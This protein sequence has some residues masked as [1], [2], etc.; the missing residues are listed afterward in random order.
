MYGNKDITKIPARVVKFQV[1]KILYRNSDDGYTIFKAKFTNYPYPAEEIP[2]SEIIIIGHFI[3]IQEE[4]EF[5][6][7]GV[8]VENNTYGYQFK[9]N[10]AEMHHPVS[11]KGIEKFLKRFVKGI[12][13]KTA[14]AIVDTYKEETL[15]VIRKDCTALLKIPGIGEKR[16]NLIHQK[17]AE[18]YKFEQIAMFVLQHGVGYKACMRIYETFGDDSIRKIKEDPY[19]LFNLPKITFATADKF[20]KN[21]NFKANSSKRVKAG[22]RYYIE[23]RMKNQGDLFVFRDD[24]LNKVPKFLN[25]YGE[26]KNI[27]KEELVTSKDV[28]KVIEELIS[29]K[30]IVIENN[31]EGNECVYLKFYNEVENQIVNLLKKLIEEKKPPIALSSQIDTFIENYEKEHSFKFAQKQKEAI[32]MAIGNGI[33]IL[34]GGPGTGKTQT[35]NSIIKCIKSIKPGASIEL[36]A[37]TGK[38]SKRM[39]ELSGMEAKTI[40]RLIGLNGF[41]KNNKDEVFE[42]MADFLIIDESSMIDAYVFYK[43]LEAINGDTRVLIVGDY[44]QL[45]SVGP[46]LILRDLIASN[47][48]PTTRLTEIFRQAQE[49]QIVM[50]SHK[51]IKGHTTKGVNALTFDTSKNDF[52]FIEKS[53]KIAVQGLLIKCIENLINNQGY[54]ISDIQMLSPIRMGD[55]GTFELNRLIQK[56][57]NPPHV[58]KQEVR[59]NATT[60]FRVGDRVIQTINN[61][62]LEVFNGEV[63]NI[64]SIENDGEGFFL[65]VDFGDKTIVYD[66]LSA[67]ELLLAYVITIHK[68]QGSEFPVVIMPIHSS[69]D[70]ML[71][72][73]LVYTAWTR[74][75][76]RVVCVGTHN[77]LDKAI[78]KT[79]NTVR[80]SLIK[81]KLE[82]RLTKLIAS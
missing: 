17:I 12:G 65:E 26:F 40:H 6:G 66:S 62:D 64:L 63:G 19:I 29:E 47:K 1:K 2:T 59:V 56:K 82:E 8:W 27:K 36:C 3:S 77:A 7:E 24:I 4:D 44:D 21:L 14:K 50:N 67:E 9:L 11:Q 34:T 30:R 31:R 22:V 54:K 81:D 73:N 46:G 80:N 43:L 49:S 20:A 69:H 70:L 45:P 13:A 60:V 10:W 75:K 51:L 52:Y 41:D 25:K 15:N 37:P 55:L 72:R 39:T 18:H 38:A 78:E 23:L 58:N 16:A 57:F 68:S 71:N 28:D 79:D 53:D 74:A 61:Y 5:K 76:E 42:I 35:I 48:I 32:Y 33:S